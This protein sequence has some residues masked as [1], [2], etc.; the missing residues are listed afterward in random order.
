M[1]KITLFSTLLL[2]SFQCFA[3]DEISGKFSNLMDEYNS[4]ELFSG[5]AVLYKDDSPVYEKTFGY[6]DWD[7]KI[8]NNTETLFNICSITKQFTRTMI[9]QLEKEGKLK[10]DDPLSKYLSLYPEESGNK[11]TIQLLLDMKAGLG[12]YLMDPEFDKNPF[13][14]KN[15]NDF[16]EIIKNEPILYEPG[17][18]QRYSNSGYVVL[19]GIIEKV[20]GKSYEK[21]LSERIL[22]P[23]GMTNTY[24]MRHDDKIP[25]TAVSADIDFTGKKNNAPF[26][27]SPSPAGGIYTNVS[28]MLKFY[29]GLKEA[30]GLKENFVAAGG[31]ETWN[32]VLGY[33]KNGYTL[34]LLGNFGRMSDEIETRFE[35][36]L[37]G[38]QYY[39]PMPPVEVEFYKVLNEK[40][41]E[42]FKEHFKEIL[43]GYGLKYNDMHL[44]M[45]G[46]QLMQKNNLDLAIEVFKI[47]SELFPE[48]PNV[49]DSLGEAYMN[50]GD[51]ETAKQNYKKVLELDPQN[52]NAK[53]MLEK[54]DH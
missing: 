4:M 43:N 46:Y 35:Q 21:N 11:I 31:T 24:F 5:V 29:K 20:T 17:T 25:N 2:F 49:W 40:G 18:S 8:P 7:K 3:Q 33:Y 41:A 13:K 30:R 39:R 14:F 52:G 37:K 42:Y 10:L 19:G 9:L 36:I 51:K 16:L 54:L 44:N 45:F 47:N 23:W 32:S 1:K 6:A 26:H 50:K 22:E 12:D 53:K 28:D 27:S 34:I 48:I 15:V 38:E